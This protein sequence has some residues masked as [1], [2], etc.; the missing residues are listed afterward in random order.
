M[1]T[2]KSCMISAGVAVVLAD[3]PS[4]RPRAAG[5]DSWPWVPR[6][7]VPP[8]PGTR[9]PGPG[10]GATGPGWRVG[11]PEYGPRARG[12]G[13]RSSFFLAALGENHRRPC[14]PGCSCAKHHACRRLT[15]T[16]SIPDKVSSRCQAH[17]QTSRAGSLQTQHKPHTYDTVS[18]PGRRARI[19]G[20]KQASK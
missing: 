12:P 17:G 20:P 10:L 15:S 7:W 13:S 16:Q 8:G 9:A 19:A 4:T 6:A 14:C 3:G 11:A 5:L 18:L 1:A 2:A